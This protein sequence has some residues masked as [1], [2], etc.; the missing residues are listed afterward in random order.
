MAVGRIAKRK[1]SRSLCDQG[2]ASRESWAKCAADENVVVQIPDRCL[3]GTGVVKQIVRIAIAVEI[4]CGDQCPATGNGRANSSTYNRWSREVPD[5]C[6][7]RTRNEQRIIWVAVDIKIRYA[8]QA[9]A[10]RKGW[11]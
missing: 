2:P 7:T 1:G 11:S 6:L 5:D 8:L 10:V 3:T 4:G 9:P